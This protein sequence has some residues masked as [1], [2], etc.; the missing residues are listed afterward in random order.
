MVVGTVALNLNGN[1][2][3][4]TFAYE[5]ATSEVGIAGGYTIIDSWMDRERCSH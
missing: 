5:F 3:V 1:R 2:L 4:G